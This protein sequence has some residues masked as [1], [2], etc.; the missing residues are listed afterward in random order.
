[1]IVH[2]ENG[3]LVGKQRD[4]AA[5]I[6]RLQSEPELLVHIGRRARERC[7]S[8]FT[9]ERLLESVG[10]VYARAAGRFAEPPPRQIGAIVRRS[11]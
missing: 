6:Q 3:F 11:P 8:M 1:M 5:A 9:L 7:L 2:G 10:D 4:F